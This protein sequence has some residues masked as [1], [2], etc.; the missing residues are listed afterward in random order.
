MQPLLLTS[1]LSCFYSRHP[2]RSGRRL[3]FASRLR[4]PHR[5]RLVCFHSAASGRGPAWT[6][7]RL[8][9]LPGDV[10]EIR[11]G[12]LYVNQINADKDLDPIHIFKVNRSDAGAIPH[13][14]RL[15]YTIP[16]Y[17]DIVYLSLSA[18]YVRENSL[19]CEQ[20]LLPPGLRT[21]SIFSTYKK[22]W[23]ED[24]FG[25]VKVP[26]GQWFV[27]GDDRRHSIDSRHLGFIDP[28]KCAGTVL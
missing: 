17:P 4:K 28:A 3:F 8:C 25:P 5:F 2:S 22:N 7:H 24:N 10:I 13:D 26:A 19:P 21:D 12:I 15:A 1:L 18:K 16:S 9:G 14:P 23:N 20:H 6:I 11:K 27:L